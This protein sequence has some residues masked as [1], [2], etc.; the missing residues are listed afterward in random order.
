MKKLKI[1]LTILLTLGIIVAGV[2]L[3]KNAIDNNNQEVN[4]SINIIESQKGKITANT[5]S[6]KS[7]ETII[8]YNEVNNGYSFLH[9]LVDGEYS[10]ESFVMPNHDVEI[11]AEYETIEY[12]VEFSNEEYNYSHFNNIRN[13]TVESETIVLN[14]ASREGYTFLGWYTDEK[15]T[16]RID[17]IEK[18][19]FG[20]LTL[21]PEW[22]KSLYTITYNLDGG[23]NSVANPDHFYYDDATITLS[24]P[25]KKGYEFV[26]WYDQNNNLVTT[27][28]Y[29]V[30]QGENVTLTA[31]FLSNMR[32]SEDFWLITNEYDFTEILSKSSNWSDK[33]RLTSDIDL[34][35]VQDWSPIGNNVTAFTGA[36]DGQNHKIKNVNITTLDTYAGLFGR[37]NGASI[38]NLLISVNYNFS[39]VLDSLHD[40]Y[41][42]GLIGYVEGSTASV[43]NCHVISEQNTYINN[44]SL[45]IPS[46]QINIGGLVGAANENIDLILCSVNNL[47]INVKASANAYVGGIIGRN[48]N[49]YQCA[50]IDNRDI[51]NIGRIEVES[52]YAYVGGLIGSGYN[53]IISNSY[54]SVYVD[55]NNYNDK[56]SITVTSQNGTVSLGG[57]V[58]Q[59]NNGQIEYCYATLGELN[60]FVENSTVN[61][62]GI[63]GDLYNSSSVNGC[64][65]SGFHQ[66]VNGN[67]VYVNTDGS[68]NNIGSIVGKFDSQSI[69]NCYLYGDTA[70]IHG[71]LNDLSI[72]PADM[73]DYEFIVSTNALTTQRYVNENFSS[74]IW[75]WLD[76]SSL[77]YINYVM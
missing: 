35:N 43:E 68:N 73:A 72:Y 21:Y 49:L 63:C 65:V 67:N 32:D 29:S 17:Q 41:V 36:F 3:I 59:L 76:E 19:S 33:F 75:S 47:D 62:A 56:S 18:G 46:S 1:F 25:T 64:L 50:Y 60:A 51:N 57:I 61:I 6:A 69:T 54:Y 31:R 38:E 5:Y 26:G 13:Y 74:E 11:S 55:S 7:G 14:D 44:I 53:S 70:I 20:N 77:P 28:G 42:G 23:V 52:P 37:V 9:F 58:G 10:D 27:I 30:Y 34:S 4:Y 39:L 45:T 22:E 48:G 16:N 12:N 2:V 40:V 71:N 8:L 66:S 15:R 24:N